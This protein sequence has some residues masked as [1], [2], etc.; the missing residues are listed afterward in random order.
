[1]KE[2]DIRK[3][4]L[5]NKYLELV[6]EDVCKFFEYKFFE[7]INCPACGG[8]N[9]VLEFNKNGFSYVSCDRC[10]TLFVNPRPPIDMIEMFYSKSKSTS[11]WVNEFFKPVEEI[12]RERIFKPRAKQIASQFSYLK[13]GR[14]G[15]I[16]SGFGIFLEELKKFWKDADLVAIEPS[17]EMVDICISKG[18][19]VI[20]KVIEKVDEIDG[21]FDLLTSFELFEHLHNPEIFIKKIW[22]LLKPGGHVII[23]TLNG[24]GFDL[25]ILWENSKSI[26]PPHHI[27]FF[28]PESI[29]NLLEQN[30]FVIEKIETPGIL[31]WNIV[32][33]MY[34][35]ENIGIERFWKL[36][37]DKDDIVKENLQNWITSSGLS[38]HMLIVAKKVV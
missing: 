17:I 7:K 34:K 3:R 23:T 16:G 28:N 5:F 6:K 12:R 8:K 10:S 14:I 29:R 35:N 19:S 25:Q 15:D 4:E 21:N 30:K 37:C 13:E 1:M 22:K 26:F 38:S 31:D 9:H 11:F 2:E 27:N 18:L 36:I 33:G 24:Q 32:E 20:P